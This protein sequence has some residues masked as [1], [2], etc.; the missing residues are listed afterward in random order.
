MTEPVS[1][2]KSARL[3]G[4]SITGAQIYSLSEPLNTK[5]KF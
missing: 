1:T 3:K 5:D 2:L 4:V